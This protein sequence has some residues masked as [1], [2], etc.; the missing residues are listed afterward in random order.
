MQNWS[1]SFTGSVFEFLIQNNVVQMNPTFSHT[2]QV[3]THTDVRILL[4]YSDTVYLG[5]THKM[6]LLSEVLKILFS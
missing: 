2:S 1:Y 5:D 3:D 4:T 6:Q